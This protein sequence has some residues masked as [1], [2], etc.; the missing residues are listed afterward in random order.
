MN[1]HRLPLLLLAITLWQPGGAWP[2]QPG[3]QPT[4]GILWPGAPTACESGVPGYV[5]ACMVDGLRALGDVGGRKFA[6]ETRYAQGDLSRLPALAAEL[7]A[8]RAD[9]LYTYT[10]AGAEA[11]AKA[12]ATATIPIVVGPTYERVMTRLAGSL[13]RPAGN[14][15]GQTLNTGIGEQEKKCLQLLKELA[16]RTS[17]VAQ[18]RNPDHPDFVRGQNRLDAA[19]AQLGLT[20]VSVKAR[21]AADLPSAFAAIA[22]GH[23]DAIFMDDD[24]A[25][26]GSAEVRQQ[27]SA[28]ALGRRLPV[29]SSSGSFAADGALLSLGTDL[30]A[31]ARRAAFYVHRILGGAKPA[32]LPVERPTVFRLSL[33]R[34]TATALGLTIPQALLLRAD[35][36]IQ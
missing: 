22:A 25:L 13:A 36:V 35:E 1:T 19:A 20:L 15:T 27:V 18:I 32:D 11:A 17:R 14:V 12:T 23:A 24:D 34:K 5:A 31:I 33:N 29:A 9:V 28:R 21:G 10:T 2:Q 7:V 30:P 8:L 4:V 6:F 16:P 3:R 26:A